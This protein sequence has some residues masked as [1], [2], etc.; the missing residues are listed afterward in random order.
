MKCVR[1]QPEGFTLLELLVSVAL[2]AFLV[3]V[4]AM[5]FS[6]GI[7]ALQ[8][9]YNRADMYASVRTALDQMM[10][11]IPTAICDGTSSY[12]FIGYAASNSA[13]LRGADSV[14]P[15]LYFVGQIAGA[16]IGNIAEVGYWLR[17]TSAADMPPRELMRFYVVDTVGSNPNPDFELYTAPLFIPNFQ[18]GTSDLLAQNVVQLDFLYYYQSTQSANDPAWNTANNWDSRVNNVVNLDADGNDKNPDGLP[19]AVGVRVS[20]RDKLQ[21]ETPR[22]FSTFIVL[23]N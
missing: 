12:P 6:Q 18:T 5:V 22:D 3:L 17:R 15:E 23:E 8:V 14:G 16:G 19:N 9:G 10:R 1:R 13:K 2:L 11:E 21:K 4:L 7:K 20:V